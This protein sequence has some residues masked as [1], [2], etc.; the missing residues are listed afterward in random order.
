MTNESLSTDA[1][2]DTFASEVIDRSKILPV[3]VDFWAEWCNPCKM[4]APILTKLA[5]ELV[6]KFHLVKVDTDSEQQMAAQ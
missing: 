4:L 3:L 1:T 2:Q 6:G 5:D